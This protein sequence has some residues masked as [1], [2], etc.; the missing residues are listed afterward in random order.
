MILVLLACQA[1]MATLYPLMGYVSE[2]NSHE[3]SLK[4][5]F[6]H[7]IIASTA[8]SAYFTG[9]MRMFYVSN[10]KLKTTLALFKL[11]VLLPMMFILFIVLWVSSSAGF[12]YKLLLFLGNVVMMVVTGIADTPLSRYG[13]KDLFFAVL[14]APTLFLSSNI[15]IYGKLH[16]DS[17]MKFGPI[18]F[19]FIGA[20]ICYGSRKSVA[21]RNE[22]LKVWSLAALLGK[23]DSFRALFLIIS[24]CYLHGI[25]ESINELSS[26]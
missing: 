21:A 10:E 24:Y 6:Y 5:F 1:A 9:T 12:W 23:Q 26:K 2:H 3:L 14:L 8:M 17:F 25:I 22:T 7:I 15:I 4:P 18:N 11:G 16:F 19:L 13:L 20:L